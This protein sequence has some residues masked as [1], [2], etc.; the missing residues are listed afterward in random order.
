MLTKQHRDGF[1]SKKCGKKTVKKVSLEFTTNIFESW[2]AKIGA[3]LRLGWLS[4][5]QIR[6]ETYSDGTSA[7][8]PQKNEGPPI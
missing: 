4:P 1:L 8:P 6:G 5:S 7:P 3:E 2:Q